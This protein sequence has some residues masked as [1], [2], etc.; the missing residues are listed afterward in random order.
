MEAVK[1]M[2]S[3]KRL[4]P[5]Q[6]SPVKSNS[7]EFIF[8]T[9]NVF[10]DE[11]AVEFKMKQ[12]HPK[13]FGLFC[14]VK[15]NIVSQGKVFVPYMF[16]VFDYKMIRSAKNKDLNKVGV[17]DRQG[18]IGVVFDMNEVHS[19]HFDLYD[20]LKLKK[21]KTEELNGKFV[22]A[23]CTEREVYEK[24][25]ESVKWQY[26]RKVFHAMPEIT[27]A[28]K[29]KFYREAWELKLEC[30]GKEYI[31]YAYRDNFAAKNEHI[32]GLRVR[33]NT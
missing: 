33:L 1:K 21:R 7:K 23:N 4:G 28:R 20:D 16:L 14:P 11:E 29:E 6:L 12:I 25:V 22:K 8:T 19:F 27:L 17:F 32:S 5:K 3:P 26:L 18:Q 13:M 31:K 24:S 10:S 2:S 15:Y 30:R 9:P